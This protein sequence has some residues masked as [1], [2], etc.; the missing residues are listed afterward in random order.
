MTLPTVPDS[1]YWTPSS[2]GPVLKCRPLEGVAAHLFTT[3][4]LQLSTAGDW[5]RAGD[6]LG[7]VG[8]Q[9]LG[10]GRIQFQ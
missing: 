1:F 5:R 7:V 2:C 6:L 3:R 9:F 10:A 4:D 8:D